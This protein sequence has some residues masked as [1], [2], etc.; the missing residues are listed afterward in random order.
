M[1]EP[2]KLRYYKLV[3]LGKTVHL[4]ENIIDTFELC[5]LNETWDEEWEKNTSIFKNK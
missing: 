2:W 5:H 4:I 1:F 3:T